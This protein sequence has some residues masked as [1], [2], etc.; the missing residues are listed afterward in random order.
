MWFSMYFCLL[1]ILD[2]ICSYFYLVTQILIF[3]FSIYVKGVQRLWYPLYIP[4]QSMPSL[5]IFYIGLSHKSTFL[6]FFYI[7]FSYFS[8]VFS[9]K[10]IDFTRN[11]S[12]HR[13]FI[14]NFF[15][16]PN[17]QRFT[18]SHSPRCSSFPINSTFFHFFYDSEHR[19]LSSFPHSIPQNNKKEPR[20]L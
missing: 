16:T 12:E 2:D 6:S 8:S 3:L 17:Q 19:H 9:H 5:P 1:A 10:P 11:P 13:H 18:F 15:L 7:L 14:F 4:F 20:F